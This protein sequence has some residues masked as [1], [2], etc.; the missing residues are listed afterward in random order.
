MTSV[1]NC[2][3][4]ALEVQLM[5]IAIF[6]SSVTSESGLKGRESVPRLELK[7]DQFSHLPFEK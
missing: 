5:F 1:L 4:P 3:R 2:G 6:S 7:I